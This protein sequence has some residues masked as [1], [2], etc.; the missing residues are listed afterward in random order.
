MVRGVP[1]H[2]LGEVKEGQKI[3]YRGTSMK[4]EYVAYVPMT[5]KW[6][7]NAVTITTVVVQ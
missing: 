6:S 1:G 4:K 7:R 3:D 2:A 5:A